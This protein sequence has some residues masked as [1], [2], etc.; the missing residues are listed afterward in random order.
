M[1]ELGKVLILG[2]GGFLGSYIARTLSRGGRHVV[3]V[4]HGAARVGNMLARTYDIKLPSP[5]L[6]GIVRYEKPIVC[7]HA[8]GPASVPD[9]VTAPARDLQASLLPWLQL[10]DVIRAE[11]PECRAIFLSSAAVYGQP[12]DM[13]ITEHSQVSPISPYG[14]HRHYCELVQGEYRTLFG[15]QGTALRIF[16]AYGVGLR[17]QVVWDI[18]Q[19][20]LASDNVLLHGLGDETR[21]FIHAEDVADAVALLLGAQEWE[22]VY[23]LASG[24]Q[25]SIRTL[26]ELVLSDLDKSKT[27]SFDRRRQEGVPVR[28]HADISRL[29]KLGFEPRRQLPEGIR[30]VLDDCRRTLVRDA[31]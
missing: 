2:A 1:S 13:P 29:R 17:K 9:S 6:A 12:Q 31:Q 14:F 11:R 22:P 21:D 25:T 4:G 3:G 10:L 8:A 18:C 23:N 15:L 30:E 7:I 5:D 19:K 28:W 16:S 20:A 26:A 24:T 27:L